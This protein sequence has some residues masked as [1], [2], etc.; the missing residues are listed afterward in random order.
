[1]LVLVSVFFTTACQAQISSANPTYPAPWCIN[2]TEDSVNTAYEKSVYS[3]T[4]TNKFTNKII[5]EGTLTYELKPAGKVDSVAYSTLDMSMSITY[6]EF[7][8]EADRGKTDTITSSVTFTSAALSATKSSRTVT[9][10]D[11]EGQ[12]NPS[13]TL[14]NDYKEGYSTLN[15]NGKEHTINF[16]GQSLI[17]IIDNELLYF[18]TRAY[19]GLN[20]GLV[21]YFKMADFFDMHSRGDSFTPI[22]MRLNTA[23]AGKDQALSF[24]T[25]TQFLND[26]QGSTMTLPTNVSKNTDP[27]GPPTQ[28]WFSKTNFTV[29]ENQTTKLVLVYIRTVEYDLT[30]VSVQFETDYK[31]VEYSAQ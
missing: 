19:P 3:I 12:S 24:P 25:L 6:N 4:K 8:Q 28:L 23:E 13:Y 11:R 27:T 30:T 31:L 5:A 16:K 26:S 1:M 22:D 18:Y 10:A 20:N 15:S 9:I 17:G 29:G 14:V 21:G 2:Q 7:A